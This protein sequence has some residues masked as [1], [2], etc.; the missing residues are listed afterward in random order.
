MSKKRTW[1]E[2]DFKDQQITKKQKLVGIEPTV[3]DVLYS[4]CYNIIYNNGYL[5][6]AISD[7]GNFRYHTHVFNTK[8]NT[9]II[10]KDVKTDPYYSLF[11][12]LRDAY[13]QEPSNTY[14]IKQCINYNFLRF[15]L[16]SNIT[17][18]VNGTRD[19]NRFGAMT[20]VM[21]S[22]DQK[23]INVCDTCNGCIRQIDVKTGITLTYVGLDINS[24]FRRKCELTAPY[25]MC[26][27]PDGCL[28]I[29]DAPGSIYNINLNGDAS[30]YLKMP[31]LVNSTH[32][33]AIT[34]SPD[35]Q[36]L[37]VCCQRTIYKINVVTKQ[38]ILFAGNSESSFSMERMNIKSIPLSDMYF[39]CIRDLKFTK[40][41]NLFVC[42]G[43]IKQI[44]N[45]G[46]KPKI[47]I[48]V[49]I[50]YKYSYLSV[51]IIKSMASLF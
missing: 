39:D 12:K 13:N 31:K 46:F 11:I 25:S 21:M 50:L 26:Y 22:P 34:M 51:D 7:N 48:P 6:G 18:Y 14:I 44:Y 23:I 9:L 29:C 32:L 49:E 33:P 8:D 35:N 47:E 5:I 41:N 3:S 27:L 17:G 28:L 40:D 30:L 43:Y 36:W 1:I 16:N 2:H 15:I 42:D 10:Y 4:N 45:H 38:I 24:T 37:I 19:N 20:R